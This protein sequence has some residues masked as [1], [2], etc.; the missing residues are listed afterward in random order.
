MGTPE[1]MSPEQAR[2]KSVDA[3]SDLFSLGCVLYDMC[4]GQTP[5][6]ADE[7]MAVLLA[8]AA[9]NP[10]A[11]SELNPNVPQLLV[12][13]IM[14]LLAKHPDDRVATARMAADMMS[15][16]AEVCRP[17]AAS[18]RAW[19]PKRAWPLSRQIVVA[20]VLAAIAFGIYWYSTDAYRFITHI[21]YRMN[22][23]W[24]VK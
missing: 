12:I 18:E 13:L 4:A 15:G 10:R 19:R 23:D 8:L 14:R 20:L 1:Y 11:L 22:I 24:R 7:T 2:G 9:D 16:I 5:F 3:R 21:L 6:H 17:V